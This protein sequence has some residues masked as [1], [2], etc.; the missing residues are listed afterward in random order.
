MAP[1]IATWLYPNGEGYFW[2]VSG[3]TGLQNDSSLNFCS[4]WSF[5]HSCVIGPGAKGRAGYW[6]K[7]HLLR[8]SHLAIVSRAQRVELRCFCVGHNKQVGVEEIKRKLRIFSHRISLYIS[9]QHLCC[10][11]FYFWDEFSRFSTLIR[12][13]QV[14]KSASLTG[15]QKQ[16]CEASNLWLFRA[17]VHVISTVRR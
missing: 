14:M 8:M 5:I 11:L 6:G 12:L 17:V 3:E 7:R 9:L 2:R 10:L 15:E 4:L 13:N 1:E 16:M